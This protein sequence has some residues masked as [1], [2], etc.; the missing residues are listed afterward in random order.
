M[1]ISIITDIHHGK[2]SLTCPD[3]R[4]PEWP[5]LSAVESFVERAVAERADAILEL[6]DRIADFDRD[7]DH[8]HASELASV[9]RRFRGERVHVLGNHDA[10]NLSAADNEAIFESPVQS[11]VVDLGTVRLVV[12]QPSVAFDYEQG[13]FP[14]A[15]SHLDWLLEALLADDRPAIVATHVSLAGRAQ[16]GNYY[17]HHAPGYSTYPDHAVIRAA[18]EKT[19]RVAVWLAGHSHWNTV[20]TIAGIQHITIQSLTERYTTYPRTAGAYADLTV[21]RGHFTLDVYGNDPFHLR[22]PFRKSGDQPWVPPI[23]RR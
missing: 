5:V 18:V 23:I 21:D 22:L 13:S 4:D 11:R 10:V 14:P 17:H 12:W 7:S 16:T 1:K 19:G 6:G 15:S 8:R 20:T 2:R 9:F 3:L